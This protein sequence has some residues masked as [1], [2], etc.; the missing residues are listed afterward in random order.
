MDCRNN[1]T[2][3]FLEYLNMYIPLQGWI[4]EYF[5]GHT[6]PKFTKSFSHFFI[7]LNEL[8]QDKFVKLFNEQCNCEST[9]EEVL[10][11]MPLF[12]WL[13]DIIVKD[14]VE[15]GDAWR[16]FDKMYNERMAKHMRTRMGRIN[17]SFGF[18]TYVYMGSDKQRLLDWAR[19]NYKA[20]NTAK[21]KNKT[22]K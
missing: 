15:Y 13:N 10:I 21:I 1:T 4:E 12:A 19:Y 22:K 16:I 20:A 11:D 7:N 14:M 3:R 17:Y 9:R 6:S 8:E 2:I 5:P 18:L